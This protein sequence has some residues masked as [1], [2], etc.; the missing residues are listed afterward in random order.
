[1]VKPKSS[2][3]RVA[4]PALVE[5]LAVAK[6][7]QEGNL[8]VETIRINFKAG[9]M[10]VHP[11]HGV[12]EVQEIEDK[13]FGGK[14]TA[15]YVIKI[16]DSGLKVMVP[17]EAASR[18]GLRPVMKKKEAQKILDIL[19]AP[20]VAVDL[21]PWNRRFRAYTEM[22]KSGLPSEIAKVLRDMYR[23]KFDKDLSFG[24][25]RLLD[26]ARSLLVQELALARKVPPSTMEGEIQ[27][28]FSA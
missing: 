27:Q 7:G 10:A 18:V 14:K 11:A 6:A 19:K 23:L 9:D 1:V 12:G 16:R 4:A 5:R 15:C 28:I 25:R 3:G 8:S 26:Q 2:G 17:T 22:L 21:Q 13:D 20:E 24:E